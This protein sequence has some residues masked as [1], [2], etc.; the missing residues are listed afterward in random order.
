MASAAIRVAWPVPQGFSRSGFWV[1]VAAAHAC[2]RD[3]EGGF[4][5]G[6]FWG[7]LQM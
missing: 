3:W 6:C 5:S 2:G 7:F 1:K 4:H